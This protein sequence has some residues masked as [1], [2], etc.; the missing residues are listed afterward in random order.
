MKHCR[1]VPETSGPTAAALNRAEA[2]PNNVLA[3]IITQ[4][5]SEQ[6]LSVRGAAKRVGMSPAQLSRV[7][8]GIYRVRSAHLANL[9][10]GLNLSPD[11]VVR[12]IYAENQQAGGGSDS[13]AT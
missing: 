12:A 4:A 13:P 9:I 8:R 11:R 5:V 1:N 3:Q 2:R 7:M 10:V 6:L